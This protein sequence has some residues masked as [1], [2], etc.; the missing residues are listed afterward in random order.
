MSQ[1]ESP[2]RRPPDAKGVQSSPRIDQGD[3]P[4][5]RRKK[6]GENKPIPEMELIVD[7]Q[8]WLRKENEKSVNMK[9]TDLKIDNTKQRGQIRSLNY[10][11][12]A[13]KVAGYQALPPPGVLRVTA[14]ED[15]GMTRSVFLHKANNISAPC[16]AVVDD[17]RCRWLTLHSEWATRE[18]DMQDDSEHAASRRPGTG[19]LARILLC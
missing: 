18:R 10:D 3:K 12:V 1:Q 13:K 9:L 7:I 4:K 8:R 2:E 16:C 17:L 5:K 6:K 15:R 11:D 19:E 14:G